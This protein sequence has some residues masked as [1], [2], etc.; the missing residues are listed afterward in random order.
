MA[1]SCAIV[2]RPCDPPSPL[3]LAA[4]QRLAGVVAEVVAAEA[5]VELLA[6]ELSAFEA[7]WREATE[8]AFAELERAQRLGRRLQRL[9]DEL[10]RLT[11]LARDGEPAADRRTAPPRPQAARRAR[12]RAGARDEERRA[13]PRAPP[14]PDAAPEDLKTL[15]RRLARLLHP[16]LARGGPAERQRRSDLMAKA[17]EAWR[18]R[19]RVALELLAERLGAGEPG[20]LAELDDRARLA[21]LARRTGAMEAAL[22][23]LAGARAQLERS[24][25]ARLRAD[26]ARRREAGGDAL[27]EAAQLAREQAAAL[28]AAALPRLDALALAARLLEKELA[29]TGGRAAASPLVREAAGAGRALT[30]GARALAERLAEEARGPAPWQ[31]ALTLLAWLAEEAGRPPAPLEEAAELA[32]RWEALCAGW[33]GAPDL[34][35]ALAE[36]PRAV[37]V[38]LRERG[39][40]IAAGLQLAAPDLAAGVRAALADE[41]VRAL[42]ARVL[43]ALGPREACRAC[44]ESVYAVHLLRVRGIEDVH[45]LACPRCAAILRS[46]FVYGPPEG[47]AAL[48]PAAVACGLVAEQEVRLDG[49]TLAFQML[50]A[51]R[52]RLTA[53]ALVRRATELC[54][55]PHGI[56]LPRGALHVLAGRAPLAA[57]ARVPEGARLRLACAPSAG[58][59]ERELVR[60]VRAGARRRFRA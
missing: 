9:L 5:A 41:G 57:G 37:E 12:A 14:G 6:R 42:A 54:L 40:G 2:L 30:S 52:A 50:P 49:A 17:N 58:V 27:A 51:E 48:G 39:E 45:G 4:E 28:R 23:R 38:G 7:S 22:A 59:S 8:A 29:K 10:A 44:G 16:D 43:V 21:H 19:D 13:A 1:P 18:R 24:T 33:T 60:L 56:A 36:P 31:A 25:E 11:G 35:T 53:R 55:A 26:A 47:V 46:F 3:V 20:P 15:Y 32:A 34:A